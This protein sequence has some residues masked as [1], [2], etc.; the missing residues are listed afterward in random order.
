MTRPP[1][2]YILLGATSIVCFGGP[3]VILLA[4][5]GGSR[6]N[7]PPESTF[8]WTATVIVLGLAA[9][10]LLTCLSIRLWYP[11]LQTGKEGRER[12]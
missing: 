12:S 7:W 1:L 9:A 4:L 8:E 10:L 3:F 11:S 2:P 6:P 5:R